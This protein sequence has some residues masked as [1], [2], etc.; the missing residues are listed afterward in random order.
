MCESVWEYVKLYYNVCKNVCE[1][2]WK[3]YV[4]KCMKV[5]VRVRESVWDCM[6]ESVW[7][8]VNVCEYA[9]V[10]KNMCESAQE[11][12]NIYVCVKV[13]RVYILSEKV[14]ENVC[15]KCVSVQKCVRV[16]KK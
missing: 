7:M 14:Y 16:C 13:I 1:N 11:C 2:V 3:I 12:K 6:R 9:R 4:W 5:Y 15:E 8:C 10:C